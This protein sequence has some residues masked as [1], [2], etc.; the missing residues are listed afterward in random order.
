MRPGHLLLL[1][2]VLLVWGALPALGAGTIYS[3]PFNTSP[4]DGEG[5]T[6]EGEWEYG[7]PQG[8]GGD[9][10]SASTGS[11][12]YGYD[13]SGNGQYENSIPAHALTTTALDCTGLT[14]VTLRFWRWLGVENYIFDN[15]SIEVS[16]DGSGWTTV[17]DHAAGSFTDSSWTEVEYD[18]SAVADG[19][20]TVYIRWVMGPTDSSV[21]YCGWNIDDVEILADLT[22]ILAW[23]P[24]TDLVEEYPRTLAALDTYYPYYNVTDSITDDAAVLAAELEGK[25][26]FLAME[27]EGAT[28]AQLVTL[29]AEFADVLTEF[30]EQGGTVVV[31]GERDGVH[32]GFLDATGLMSCDAVGRYNLGEA[33][34]VVSPSHPLAFGLGSSVAAQDATN[35]YAVGPEA[36]VVVEDPSGNAVVA[37]RLLG[38][39]AAIVVGYDYYAHDADAERVIANAV[40]YPRATGDIL[41]YDYPDDWFHDN[42]I[43]QQALDAL[44]RSYR[45]ASSHDFDAWLTSKYWG[46]VVVDAPNNRP[47]AGFGELVSFLDAGGR[48][49]VSTWSLTSQPA[50]CAAFGVSAEE[51]FVT[52]QPI[53]RWDP[54]HELFTYPMD[55]PDLTTWYDIW[56]ADA[57]RLTWVSGSAELVAGFTASPTGGQAAIVIADDRRILNGFLWDASGTDVDIQDG[58]SDGVDDCVELVINE[59]EYLRPGPR[60][61]FSVSAAQSIAGDVLDF[62]DLSDGS[63]VAWYWQFGDGE[64]SVEQDPSHVYANPGIYTVTFTASN[65]YGQDTVTETDYIWAGFSDVGPLHWAF[66]PVLLCADA[67]IVGGYGDGTYQPALVVTRDTMAVFIARAAAGGDTNV[68]AGPVVATFD[69]V[70][71]DYWAYKYIEYC[72]AE[73]I[74]GGYDPVTYGPTVPVTRDQMSVFIS[75]AVAGG[76]GNVP[77]GP[78]DATFDDVPTDYWAYKYIEYC[79]AESIVQGYDPVTYGPTVVVTRDQMAVFISRAYNLPI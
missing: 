2:C 68:P 49:T 62:T 44:G 8:L 32:E 16:N 38:A 39:G 45:T 74:V 55:V 18:I 41:L 33:L 31:L 27:Q 56:V 61:D 21:T 23:I 15:A 46:L 7:A 59:I 73:D 79:V 40:Q 54:S 53:Y 12:V 58:D 6:M 35:S 37:A 57:D 5:W 30:V 25:D 67:E 26:V 43:A 48:A 19:Q 69:D 3:F 34:P 17:W 51:T 11:Y 52:P 72:V 63:P 22:E 29:G 66:E 47:L 70:P 60:A 1:A 4:P 9:P 50:L 71:T 24:Y 77:A 10:A 42:H 76:D 75:R 14:N 64:T 20:P 65:P 78:V 36:E 13:L 28:P